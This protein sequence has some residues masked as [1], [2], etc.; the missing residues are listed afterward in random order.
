[1]NIVIAA[2]LS[3][4]T[5]ILASTAFRMRSYSLNEYA[6]AAIHA[7]CRTTHHTA[8]HAYQPTTVHVTACMPATAIVTDPSL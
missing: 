2:S 3:L 1:M 4:P 6:A 8:H 5:I 7:P